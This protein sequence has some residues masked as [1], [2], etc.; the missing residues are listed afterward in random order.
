[1]SRSVYDVL[2]RLLRS[3][4]FSVRFP[5][6]ESLIRRIRSKVITTLR[7]RYAHGLNWRPKRTNFQYL[8]VYI[9]MVTFRSTDF[10]EFSF[11]Q[12]DRH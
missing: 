2:L 11:V 10:R 12:L 5:S 3:R 1:M 6:N 4:F 8:R 7:F 9:K